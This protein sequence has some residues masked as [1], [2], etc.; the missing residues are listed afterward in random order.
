MESIISK[1]FKQSSHYFSGNALAFIAHFISFPILTRALSTGDYGTMN[2]LMVTLTLSTAIGKLGLQHSA[3]RFYSESKEKDVNQLSKYYSTLFFSPILFGIVI[4]LIAV[5]SFKMK[6]IPER[7]VDSSMLSLFV[8][9][10]M[11][12]PIRGTLET[13]MQFLRAEQNTKLF[14]Y[15]SVALRYGILCLTIFF[16]FYIV[17]GLYGFFFGMLLANAIGLIVIYSIIRNS[18][19][20]HIKYFSTF[21][22]KECLL[23]GLPMVFVEI[24]HTLLSIGDRYL[25]QYFIGSTALGIYSAG[26]NLSTYVSEMLVT[27]FNAA[28]TPLYLS[29]WSEQGKEA[30]KIFL[31]SSLRYLLLILI[32]VGFGFAG[33]SANL[34]SLLASDKYAEAQIII[35]WVVSG[36]VIYGMRIVLDAPIY[37]YKKTFSILILMI[38]SC[39]LNMVLNFFMIPVYGIKGA[40]IATLISNTVHV[41]MIV[42]ISFRLLRY[43]IDFYHI[44]IY[45]I[46][47]ALMYLTVNQISI[48]NNLLSLFVKIIVGIFAYS[49]LVL[50]LDK[51][52]RQSLFMKINKKK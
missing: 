19:K 25:I 52:I 8:L 46:S 1:F 35:P 41:G 37:I 22:L 15:F 13:S 47:S 23:F 3:I 26:Y 2:L 9:V 33:V 20:L 31:T 32:P 4:A 17:K 5:V 27:P 44:S 49:I 34:I 48:E 50:V 7:F 14:N 28:S 36:I 16:L 29:I 39:S 30:T 40:A 11:L 42:F 45:I 12:V 10:S 24:G 21:F 18:N 6:F 38:I 51:D 43:K